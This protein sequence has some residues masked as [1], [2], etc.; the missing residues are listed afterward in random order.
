MRG[1]MTLEEIPHVPS[2]TQ[3]SPEII[4]ISGLP[5]SGTSLMMNML[6]KGGLTLLKDDIRKADEDN[7][8]GYYEY[9]PVK[10]LKEGDFAWMAQA[11]GKVVKIISYLLQQLPAS[12]DYRVIFMQRNLDE[13]I[14]SQRKMLIRREEDPDKVDDEKI[15]SI[16][17]NHLTEIDQWIR[18]QTNIESIDIPYNRLVQDAEAYLQQINQFLDYALD[19]QAM[20]RVIDPSLYRQRK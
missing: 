1:D 11:A 20:A 12:Y 6:E 4:V 3:T 18:K 10:K 15:K 14:A 16:L 8:L 2:G 5:R 13:I 7:P 17:E 9:E 19:V